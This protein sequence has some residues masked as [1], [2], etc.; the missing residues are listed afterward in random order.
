MWGDLIV[1]NGSPW[2]KDCGDEKLVVRAGL[3]K[4]R[5]AVVVMGKMSFSR[6]RKVSVGKVHICPGGG[7]A[8]CCDCAGA[9]F[10]F[11]C[12]CGTDRRVLIRAGMREANGVEAEAKCVRSVHD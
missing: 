4:E 9:G 10:E 8:K 11:H 1:L 7:V 5:V 6:D 2:T 12:N 3:I